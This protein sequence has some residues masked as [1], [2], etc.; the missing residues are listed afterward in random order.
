MA[1]YQVN[2]V[3]EDG[4]TPQEERMLFNVISGM[5]LRMAAR[6]AG[7]EFKSVDGAKRIM[8]RPHCKKRLAELKATAAARAKISQDDVLEGFKEAISDAKLLG[9]PTA[10]IS[11]WREVAKMLGFYAP[12]VKKVEISVTERKARAEL[13]ELSEDDL[14][15][16]LEEDSAIDG[17]FKV[18]N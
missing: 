13:A 2:H 18:L 7:Y 15:A 11:G 4:I 6:E 5:P 17:E 1:R 3:D 14:N 10:Q 12:D 16:L 8:K 9:D